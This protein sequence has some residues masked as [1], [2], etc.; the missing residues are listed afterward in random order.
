MG[1]TNVIG[2]HFELTNHHGE[3]VR[4]DNYR[5]QFMLVY[6][7][8]THCR[9]VCP[10]ALAKLSSVLDRIGESAKQIEA[11]YVT[12]DPT[13]DT[14]QVMKAYLEAKYPRFTGLTG[15]VEQIDATK[16]AFRIFAERKADEEDPDG[17]SVP[18]TA[19]AYLMGP[20]GS[21]RAHFPDSLDEETVASRILVN[22]ENQ[23][24]N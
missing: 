22:L 20:D 13:R 5:G 21:Y 12:V 1:V 7:G 24:R 10:R 16:R 9:V 8:F 4:D 19:I 2:G 14:P 3:T 11:L 15:T 18:H 23:S 17:Y 6:F